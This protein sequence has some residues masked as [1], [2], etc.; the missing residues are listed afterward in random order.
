V[1]AALNGEIAFDGARFLEA[2][3]A[4]FSGVQLRLQVSIGYEQK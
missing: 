4:A 2:L 1:I 3:M